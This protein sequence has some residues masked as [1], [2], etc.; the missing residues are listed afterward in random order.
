MM[1]KYF[2]R[3]LAGNLT[4]VS[5]LASFFEMSKYIYL[6][7]RAYYTAAGAKMIDA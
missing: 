7:Y 2:Y 1:P 6:I 3:L 4:H 5:H